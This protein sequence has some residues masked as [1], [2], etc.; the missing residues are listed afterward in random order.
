MW[1]HIPTSACS[2]VPVASTSLSESQ[3]QALAA[4]VTVSGKDRQPPYWLRA[5]PKASW[6]RR[7]SGLTCEPSL[8]NSIV[9]AWMELSVGFPAPISL[10]PADEPESPESTPASGLNT[11]DSFA[12]FNPDGS[13]SRTSRQCSIWEQDQPYSENLPR[14][15]SMRSGYL[16]ERPTLEL[17]IDENGC[18]SMHGGAWM[19]PHGMNGI[20]STGK[21][22]A[23]GEFAKQ[24][25]NWPT[26]SANDDN[27]SPEAYR[28]MREHKLGRTG[29]AAETVSSLNVL[30]KMWPTPRSEDSESAGN[31]PGAVDSLTGATK[32]WTTPQ[33]HDAAGGNPTRV[34]RHGTKHGC[35]NLADDVT[36]WSTPQARDTHNP[37]TPDSE[38]S[39]RK[40]EQGWTI[41]LNEQAAWWKPA[42]AWPTPKSRDYRSAEGPAGDGRQSPDLN[43]TA[44]RFSLLAP[45]TSTHGGESSPSGQTSRPRLNPKFA[46]WLMGW[47]P[48]YTNYA[49]SET[50][51]CLWLERLRTEFL[52][53]VRRTHR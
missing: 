45:E 29:K 53:I 23:G 16:F 6:M 26:P 33:A 42:S 15:G 19:T 49:L 13:L 30:V 18:S 46:A 24:A 41:D 52:R 5:W 9:A 37:S 47:H 7:L 20:D 2:P 44:S 51:S 1:L 35:A 43:V 34:R 12:K 28:H 48:D 22:G 38:R 17:H 3:S 21:V 32:L 11:L 39:K 25:T 36:L 10:L 14:N 27:K 4:L 31:H 40:A 8:A 50:G